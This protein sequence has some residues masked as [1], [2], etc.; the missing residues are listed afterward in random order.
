M[1]RNR[2]DAIF[3]EMVN[4]DLHYKNADSSVG[5]ITERDIKDNQNPVQALMVTTKK[6]SNTWFIAKRLI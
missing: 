1:D 5:I 4:K 3:D 2:R 6:V